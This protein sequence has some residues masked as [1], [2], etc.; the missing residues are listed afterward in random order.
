LAL[1]CKR[2]ARGLR[3]LR[4]GVQRLW[5]R[6]RRLCQTLQEPIM[7]STIGR[8]RILADRQVRIILRHRVRYLAWKALRKTFK[9]QRELARDFGVSQGTISRVIRLRGLYKQ[10]SPD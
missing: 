4:A 10:L 5:R 1:A 9:S 2:A 7:K 8:P 3:R 6:Q